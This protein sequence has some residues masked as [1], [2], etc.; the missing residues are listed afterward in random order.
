VIEFDFSAQRAALQ[1]ELEDALAELSALRN[2][3]MAAKTAAEDACWKFANFTLRL[4]VASRYGA[5]ECA[6]AVL[7]Q[8]HQE[9]R[10]RDIANGAAERAKR[11]VQNCEWRI[12]CARTAIEQ[13]SKVETP[14]PLIPR[15]EVVKRSAPTFDVDYDPIVLPARPPADAA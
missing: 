10:L 6:P 5:D 11:D 12:G 7:N 14:P 2:A 13:L 9:R 15:R 8:L 3:H 1:A 4:N